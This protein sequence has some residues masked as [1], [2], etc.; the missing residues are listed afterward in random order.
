MGNNWFFFFT[1]SVNSN[2]MVIE[3][4]FVTQN[5]LITLFENKLPKKESYWILVSAT[6]MLE[7]LLKVK[8]NGIY[9]PKIPRYRRDNA[10]RLRYKSVWELKSAL[11]CTYY[12]GKILDSRSK[13]NP[14]WID[15]LE[16]FSSERLNKRELP[17]ILT[18]IAKILTSEYLS[19]SIQRWG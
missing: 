9:D 19:K 13:R 14:L 15:T 8:N 12:T 16:V 1:S 4:Y 2:I 18:F 3:I 11:V 6:K 5:S 7:N 10:V 17:K